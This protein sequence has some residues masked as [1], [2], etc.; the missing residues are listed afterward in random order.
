MTCDAPIILRDGKPLGEACNLEK[1][2]LGGHAVVASP[3]PK[4]SR[5][6]TDLRGTAFNE[7][8]MF[9]EGNC[10]QWAEDKFR[11]ATRHEAAACK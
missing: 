8:A 9:L 1:H 7:K 10:L 2:H 5:P 11:C 4:C 6:M 3:C